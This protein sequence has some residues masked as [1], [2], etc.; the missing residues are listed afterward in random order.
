MIKIEICISNAVLLY[1]HLD[2]HS[3]A[4]QPISSP[5]PSISGYFTAFKHEAHTKGANCQQAVPPFPLNGSLDTVRYKCDEEDN[6]ENNAGGSVWFIAIRWHDTVL[7][8]DASDA[9]VMMA[10]L[11]G[12]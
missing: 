11:A 8:G 10:E 5:V 7:V 6:D 2:A 9:S 1:G 4:I 3:L 12:Q